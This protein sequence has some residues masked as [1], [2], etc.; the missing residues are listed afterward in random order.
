MSDSLKGKHLYAH[1][2]DR[3]GWLNGGRASNVPATDNLPF[4]CHHCAAPP[5]IPSP[6]LHAQRG[7]Q[8]ARSI[9]I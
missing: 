7:Q 1:P 9:M 6:V 2:D 5:V 8:R 3:T 4:G